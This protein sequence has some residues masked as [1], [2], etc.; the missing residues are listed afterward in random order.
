MEGHVKV[1][2]S[3]SNWG[4]AVELGVRVLRFELITFFFFWLTEFKVH[5]I[6]C[7]QSKTIQGVNPYQFSNGQLTGWHNSQV[8]KVHYQTC[9]K[10]PVH[11]RC[12]TPQRHH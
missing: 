6:R 12:R 7:T 5:F 11:D 8:A 3:L 1:I 10:P 4:R 2:L 9:I